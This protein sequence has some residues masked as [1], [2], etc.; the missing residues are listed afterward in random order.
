MHSTTREAG[1][2]APET[3]RGRMVTRRRGEKRGLCATV[4]G[5]N[6][7]AGTKGPGVREKGTQREKGGYTKKAPCGGKGP[8]EKVGITEADQHHK[9]R[10]TPV[11]PNEH[12]RFP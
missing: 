6:G 9:H 10:G 3:E 12:S 4:W 1:G 8:V 5:Q 2:T 11:V 7:V